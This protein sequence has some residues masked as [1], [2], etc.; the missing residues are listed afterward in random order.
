M[1]KRIAFI[2]AMLMLVP[3]IGCGKEPGQETSGSASDT[4]Q[5]QDELEIDEST[6]TTENSVKDE[7]TPENWGIADRFAVEN[8][9]SSEIY[10]INFP[11]YAGATRGYGLMADQK[12]DTTVVVSGQ[13]DYAPRINSI[14]ELFPAYF[15]Q[16]E[17]TLQKRYGLRANNFELTLTD[18]K[19]VVVGDYDMHSFEGAIQF[20]YEE[21]PKN[22]KF[23]AYAT[24]LKSNGAYA[25]WVVY[26]TSDDQSNGELIAE[27]ALN[28][29]KTFREEQ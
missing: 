3:F 21:S 24:T 25:Y 28:M 12:N 13:N 9:I 4:M 20:D 23:I 10:C 8:E 16:L 18:N 22:Y 7:I 27:H 17:Y 15:E 14:S 1:K 11:D 6:S 2:L 26:D 29:A 5:T 19:P